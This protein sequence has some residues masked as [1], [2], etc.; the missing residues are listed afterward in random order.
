MIAHKTAKGEDTPETS[1]FASIYPGP[2]TP[3]DDEL[4]AILAK[5]QAS[6]GMPVWLCIQTHT[7]DTPFP[8][9]EQPL[10]DDFRS[11][12]DELPE[13]S[14]VALIIESPGGEA[15]AAYGLAR[16]LV[17]RCGS[18]VAVV[19]DS[20]MSA[21]TLLVLGAKSILMG[22][23]AAIGPLDAQ[24]YDH[25]TETYGSALNE[26]QALERLR[27]F[28]LESV[29][30][31]MFLMLGRTGK[32]ISTLLPDVF[33]FIADMTRPLLESIDVVH[34]NERA[35]M[36]KVAE[37]YA[38]RLLGSTQQA[39]EDHLMPDDARR[40]ASSLVEKYPEHGFP[41]DE[42]EAR[43][44]G[45][46]VTETTEEQVALLEALWPA[47]RGITVMGQLQE[48]AVE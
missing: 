38:V 28:A 5:F 27:A 42:E 16:L 34:Y 22:P 46:P 37:E 31:A 33:S 26:V 24:I 20:A 6:L 13:D 40:V 19:P 17:R 23:D 11:H 25:D 8:H 2:N 12:K 45:L 3:L 32:R 10:L 39:A 21:A 4:G 35:R 18:Y 43:G 7:S 14:P 44:L 36:L 9:L 30:S 29:D 15:R 41:I 47:I 48:G 1:Y